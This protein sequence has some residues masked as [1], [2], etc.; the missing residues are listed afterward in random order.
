MLDVLHLHR[1]LV[2]IPSVSRSEGPIMDFVQAV[3]EGLGISVERLGN[4]LIATAGKGPKVL[5]DTHLD[6]VPI[7]HAWTRDPFHVESVNG[8]V[9]GLGSNDAKAS[10]A[11]MIATLERVHVEGGPCELTLILASMEEVNGEGTELCWKHLQEAG[12][13]P[14]GV[15]VGEPTELNIGVSQKGLMIL[16]LIA[17]GMACHSANADRLGAKN[18][19]W[20]LA[21]NIT[22]LRGIDLG[23]EHPCLGK[24]T[25]QPTV[26]EG[27][28]THNQVPCEAS[29]LLDLRTVPGLSHEELADRV[30]QAV[31]CKVER[32][33][34]RLQAVQCP[35]EAAIVQAALRAR[36]A[37]ATFASPTMS[38]QA[39]FHGQ[40]AIKC[41]P[42]V[43]AR[44]H[45]GD[46]FVLESEILEA[47]D[48]YW[49][50]LQ[51][52]A[53]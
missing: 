10:A 6:T 9:F 18:P 34:L 33:S 16:R 13:Q 4:N 53:K 25:L 44:S 52:M 7:T 47:V 3:F 31:S 40:D 35:P 50:L 26:L 15:V 32:K 36:P 8:K 43:S 20:D 45:T 19:V 12:Y 22:R 28:K 39:F 51:E 37:S 14:V 46:E 29:C 23:P 5:F 49:N 24:T 38:D 1:E 41:G 30:E 48:F 27:S 17:E 11:A 21:E 2:G 42:G